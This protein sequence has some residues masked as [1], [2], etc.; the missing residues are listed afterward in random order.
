MQMGLTERDLDDVKNM[1]GS[2]S[3]YVLGLTYIISMLHMVFDFLA[4]KNDVRTA[5]AENKTRM[6][7]QSQTI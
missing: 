1:F 6:R 5:S 3:L 7:I 4:F 2:M